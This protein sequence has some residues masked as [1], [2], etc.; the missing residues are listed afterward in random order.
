MQKF[1][2]V[3]KYQNLSVYNFHIKKYDGTEGIVKY[4]AGNLAEEMNLL[5]SI[6][7]SKNEPVFY[8]DIEE[9]IDEF[10]ENNQTI[11]QLLIKKYRIQD[12]DSN[13][14]PFVVNLPKLAFCFAPTTARAFNN[15]FGSCDVDPQQ[16][17]PGSKI[18]RAFFFEFV[19]CCIPKFYYNVNVIPQLLLVSIIRSEESESRET[20]DILMENLMTSL[21]LKQLSKEDERIETAKQLGLIV[22]NKWSVEITRYRVFSILKIQNLRNRGNFDRVQQF[23]GGIF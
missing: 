7:L 17:F 9:I 13:D 8:T 15:G 23:F 12:F 4:R 5:I 19:A 21:E 1:N 16:I 14:P 2:T 22:N 3:K 20:L 11:L 10:P 18:P 6:F